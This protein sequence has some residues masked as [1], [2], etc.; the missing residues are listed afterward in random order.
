MIFEYTLQLASERFWTLFLYTIVT[1]RYIDPPRG[2]TI[3]GQ[4]TG[5]SE[6]YILGCVSRLHVLGRYLLKILEE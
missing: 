5:K 2:C 3:R 6:R 4:G 1:Q